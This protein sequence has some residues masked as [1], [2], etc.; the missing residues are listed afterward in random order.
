MTKISLSGSEEFFSNKY[1]DPSPS[2]C[3]Y[4]AYR[5]CYCEKFFYLVDPKTFEAM[6]AVRTVQYRNPETGEIAAKENRSEGVCS[7]CVK[8]M[9][10]RQEE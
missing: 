1:A 2:F 9:M 3:T 4:Y 10:Q 8:E 7:F 5:C 6:G